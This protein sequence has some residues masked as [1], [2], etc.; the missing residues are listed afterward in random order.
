M[1]KKSFKKFIVIDLPKSISEEDL[2]GQFVWIGPV[3]SVQIVNSITDQK[4]DR[5]AIVKM[6]ETRNPDKFNH[7]VQGA[8]IKG[9]RVYTVPCFYQ[10]E[11]SVIRVVDEL[12]R[13]LADHKVDGIAKTAHSLTELNDRRP[14]FSQVPK[15]KFIEFLNESVSNHQLE[16][17]H[18]QGLIVHYLEDKK[19]NI[20]PKKR[21]VGSVKTIS[22]PMGGQPPRRKRSVDSIDDLDK[23]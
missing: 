22:I 18:L 10:S 17:D 3:E 7:F 16:L 21:T 1:K 6:W 20:K 9:C 12:S 5:Y 23:M 14:E 2:K 4:N 19:K 15:D 13:L 11:K 8:M